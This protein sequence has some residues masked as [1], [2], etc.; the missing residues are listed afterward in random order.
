MKK[1]ILSFLLVL[2]LLFTLSACSES[3][4]NEASGGGENIMME[5]LTYNF[6]GNKLAFGYKVS[7]DI[8]N[9][10]KITVKAINQNGKVENF[11]FTA[12]PTEEK[13]I[14]SIELGSTAGEI[15]LDF[16]AKS[17][18][19]PEKN[20]TLVFNS[21]R[22]QLTPDSVK[23]VASA[24]NN[25]EKA[26]LIIGYFGAPEDKV[27]RGAMGLLHAV[28]RFGIPAFVMSDGP[29]GVRLFPKF[30]TFYPSSTAVASTWDVDMAEY[31]GTAIG[32]E[33]KVMG[34][35]VQ[36]GPGMTLQR[37]VL[38]GRNSEYFSEDP[39]LSGLMGAAY[40]KGVQS[41][42]TYACVK[43]FAANNQETDRTNVSSNI[44]E[45]VL[46]EIYLKNFA[47]AII[48]G[49]PKMLM[50]SYN[51]INGIYTSNFADLLKVV[52]DEYGFD[53]TITTDWTTNAD[54][55]TNILV[56]ND[57]TSPGS[58]EEYQLVKDAI[59]NGTLPEE[60][61]TETIERIL[62]LIAD[63]NS[64]GNYRTDEIDEEAGKVA[65]LKVAEA[66]IVL[67]KNTPNTLPF[68]S[69]E[70]ALF[71]VGSY[72]TVKGQQGSGFVN[73]QNN[74]DIVKAF[75]EQ[76]CGFTV[77]KTMSKV[78]DGKNS[79]WDS[80]PAEPNIPDDKITQSANEAGMAIVT[81]SRLTAEGTD[82]KN[83]KGGFLLSDD[84]ASIINRVSAAYHA[85]GKKVVVV[86]NSCNPIEV[87]SWRDKVDAILY[88]APGGKMVGTAIRNVISGKVNPSG[89]LTCT[90]PV[91]YEDTSCYETFGKKGDSDYTEGIYVGYRDNVSNNVRYAYEFGYGISYTSFS[92]SDVKLSKNEFSSADD[93]ITAEI[94]VTNTG[95]V[96]GM[97]VVQLYVSKPETLVD[98][99]ARELIG[100]DKTNLLAPGES[101]TIKITITS[102]EL[103]SFIEARDSWVVSNGSYKVS[104]AASSFDLKSS[105]TFTVAN[106][107][108]TSTVTTDLTGNN[109]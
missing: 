21:K 18:A 32:N 67:L 31:V 41:T 48:K 78:Y 72:T 46:R 47:Y 25:G 35:D 44:S 103:E 92:Y 40:I 73:S 20:A 97:E 71:G 34:V 84:E 69:G 62:T 83:A 45:R 90:W 24:L 98:Q 8:K 86:I 94:T 66:G 93:T 96:A 6:N 9:E 5:F 63:C 2:V 37:S 76:D 38:G 3:G 80:L 109:K 26:G 100:F 29:A 19:N 13:Q 11:S 108:V 22:P 106:E 43:H 59:A 89:K 49:N 23:I 4:N 1:K 64:M 53:G 91:A 17:A 95:S 81:I 65:A 104:A 55:L 70:V 33:A 10:E 107:I 105:A 79:H 75:S 27:V 57:I 36:L 99:V 52:R 87:V 16:S 88:A 61:V 85:K 15:T 82:V 51:K 50:T 101:E 54:V 68:T 42:G 74:V 7:G 58:K 14:A 56:G 28:E 39:L 60:V 30:T 77:N 102:Y 12:K